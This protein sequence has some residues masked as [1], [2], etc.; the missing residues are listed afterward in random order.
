MN[1]PDPEQYRQLLPLKDAISLGFTEQNWLELG[2]LT[3]CT[4]EVQA[5]PRL[6]RNLSWSDA[7]YEGHVLSMLVTMAEKDPRNLKEIERYVSEKVSAVGGDS[8]S[9][10]PGPKR[11]Y[12]TPQ[13][14]D[15]PEEPGSTRWPINSPQQELQAQLIVLSAG[16]RFELVVYAFRLNERRAGAM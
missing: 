8:L 11:I 15:V 12:I 7:D 4:R 13:V 9:N 3:G 14:F 6:L 10:T 5:H 1:D 16:E 2:I